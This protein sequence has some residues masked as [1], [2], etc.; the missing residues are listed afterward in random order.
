MKPLPL[1]ASGL[2]ITPIVFGGWQA[3]REFWPQAT[4]A[5]SRAAIAAA[6]DAG[7]T[8]FDTAEVYGEG[9]SERLLGEVLRPHR[10]QVVLATKASWEHLA[11]AD[12]V[13][14][15]E[16]SLRRLQTDV[17]DLYQIHWPA[18]TFDSPEVP[19]ADTMGALLD[20][21]AAG[22]IRAIGVSNFSAAELRAAMAEGPIDAI[23]PCWSLF[24]RP[25]EAETRALCAVAGITVLAYSPLAQGLLTGRFQPGH[26]FAA[27]DTR[28]DNLLFQSPHVEAATQALAAM[29]PIAARYGRPLAHLALAWLHNQPGVA[30]IVGAR[31]AR[32]AHDNAAAA[33]LRLDPADQAALDALG[34]AVYAPLADQP[35]MW[36]W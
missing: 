1:G 14:A 36:S 18:G 22:K 32:Q 11:P 3:G 29:A 31:T 34:A 9:H 16:G 17:I 2:S 15:C 25:F 27:G 8:T 6:F 35:M 21:K 20:L 4:D 19:I 12:L 23:Q 7:I 5:D 13:A 28:A 26:A 30:A 10:Q 24:W 33:D